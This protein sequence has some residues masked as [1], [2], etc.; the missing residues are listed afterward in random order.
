MNKIYKVIWSKVRNCYVAVSEIAKR[1]GKS[2]T[3]VNWGGSANHGHAGVALA[4]ALSLSLAGEGVA[5]GADQPVT[6]SEYTIGSS[7]TEDTDF[8]LNYGTRE[9][10]VGEGVSFT[11][12]ANGKV[13]TIRGDGNGRSGNTITI[14]SGG[15]VTNKKGSTTNSYS[16]NAGIKNNR[17]ISAG[18]INDSIYG[19]Y[20]EWLI[21]NNSV[22]INGGTVGGSVFGGRATGTYNVTSN[23]VTIS[24]S[25]IVGST[26]T[27]I[28]I[29]GGHAVNGNATGNNVNINLETNDKG[30]PNDKTDDTG[31][32][33]GKVYGGRSYDGNAGGDSEN[34][35]NTVSITGG[36][37]LGNIYGGEVDGGSGSAINNAVDISGSATIGTSGSSKNIHGGY[38]N[39]NGEATGNTVSINLVT[40]DKG[41]PDDTTDD[42]GV[43]WGAVYGGYSSS[44]GATGNHVELN[45]GGAIVVYGGFANGSGAV[46]N[47]TV[48]INGGTVTITV[49]GG[50]SKTG[51]VGGANI[52]DRNTVTITDGTIGNSIYGGFV[53]SGSGSAQ[54][55]KV[56]ISGTSTIGSSSTTVIIHGGKADDSGSATQ[57]EVE[58]NLASTGKIWGHVIGGYSSSGNAGGA[59]TGDG[60]TVIISGGTVSGYVRGGHVSSGAGSVQNNKVSISG[61]NTSVESVYGGYSGSTG[62][63]TKNTVTIEAGTI[64]S[65]VYGGYAYE[66]TAG[67]TGQNDG[68][69][70]TING[71]TVSKDVFGGFVESSSGSAVNNSVTVSGSSKIGTS[72]SGT[73]IYSVYG[74][75]TNNGSATQNTVTINLATGGNI[76]GAVIGGY[77]ESGS[78]GGNSSEY[79]NTV[80][81]IGGTI[82]SSEIKGGY[83]S[84]RDATNNSVIIK[85]GTFGNDTLSIYGGKSDGSDGSSYAQSNFVTLAGGSFNAGAES[86]KIIGGYGATNLS[87]NTINLYGTV[88]GL[89]KAE[90]YGYD[91]TNSITGSG[92][93]LHIGGTKTAAMLAEG[94]SAAAWTGTTGNKVGSV[95]NFSSIVLHNVNW[96]TTTPVL[97]AESFANNGI[98]DISD[99]NILGTLSPGPMALLQSDNANLGNMTLTYKDANNATQSNK[100]IGSGISLKSIS[101]SG[102]DT[103]TTGVTLDYTKA[104]TKVVRSTS[105]AINYVISP[106]FKTAT[107]GAMN[108]NAGRTFVSGDVFDSSGLTVSFGSGFKV[109][110]AANQANGQSFNLLD[111][112]ATSGT[113]ADSPSPTKEITGITGESQAKSGDV[114]LD[115]L[116]FAWSRT[117]TVSKSSDGNKL[118]VSA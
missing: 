109:T 50:Y 98:L 105:K 59:N 29:Y 9:N 11:V 36:T 85:G 78:V 3:S 73:T 23:A 118:V 10:A 67:G 76:Y 83:S 115:A 114:T 89:D 102:T 66:G 104:Q 96:S 113:I 80:T 24:E 17:V 34:E 12:N 77:S 79:G 103:A 39:G 92:N 6:S 61:A 44:G 43:I 46:K 19:G 27:S 54:N 37:V 65:D 45:S 35:G 32:I 13:R 7:T 25:A 60:N 106:E 68:N 116:K 88:T 21:T 117:D 90:L 93:A 91:S 41:T 112:S 110:G 33:W 101:L 57:N 2:C 31:V 30:T 5:L 16:I 100:A 40:N 28:S 20:Y 72:T 69:T 75:K 49:F 15:E 1:N 63:V 22:T 82:N 58:I 18:T 99:I 95:N 47:N 97:A 4:V 74:G 71:G 48:T 42:T 52:G 108:W 64:N 55:N 111:L 51:N 14:A 87:S 107:L 26:N 94:T 84:N 8:V 62:A 70:V 38:A 56:S 86:L 81:I 53:N